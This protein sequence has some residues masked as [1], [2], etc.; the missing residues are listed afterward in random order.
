[1]PVQS[2]AIP[3]R[4]QAWLWTLVTFAFL[5]QTALNLARPQMS[6]K[7]L[8]LG[9][10][11]LLIG[12]LTALYALV[13][14]FM[15]ISFGRY[16][17]KVG[18]LR[19]TVLIGGVMIGVG[20]AVMAL[21]PSIIGVGL[22][23]VLLGFGHL[24]FVIAS[25]ASVS[26]YST[27]ATLDKGFGWQTAGISAGQLLGP[28]LGGLILGNSS[29]DDRMHLINI[30]LW[31][32]ATFALISIP[33]MLWP[34]RLQVMPTLTSE[35]PLAGS[36]MDEKT[37]PHVEIRDSPGQKKLHQP[38]DDERATTLKI[39]RRP[40][41]GSNI[42]ASL[43]MLSISDILISFL[44]LVGESLG[45]S[46]AWVGVLLAIRSGAS[47]ASRSL[48]STMT[49]KWNRT[50][51]VIASLLVSA[52]VIALVPLTLENLWISVLS[53]VIG[54]F[55]VGIAQPL[56]MTMIIKEVPVSWRS[57]A[58]AVRLTGN[59][60]G[61]VCIPLIAGAVAAPLGPAG[62]IWF[63]CVLIGISGV[64][65]SARYAKTGPTA[66]DR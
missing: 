19:Y 43:A 32:G 63:C 24:I 34:V 29:G 39:L 3:S 54:G 1:M 27:D 17:E 45:V 15:A 47:I 58:L 6:Y 2:G 8:E 64:E 50:Q 14:V 5:S 4:P 48:L 38:S 18:N 66:A 21:T 61:Q 9:S 12:V 16:T 30:S 60:L 49:R 7:L 51:L 26:R 35:I 11:E 23:S 28:L 22:A 36:T 62:A 10:N 42:F 37:S 20:A 46:P 57:P 44:P 59:R 25:Q 56:T 52:I 65:K 55:F 31:V 33:L 40:G 53:M 41:V 13:P